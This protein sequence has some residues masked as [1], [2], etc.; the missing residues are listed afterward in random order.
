[1]VTGARRID[2]HA[3]RVKIARTCVKSNSMS[4]EVGQRVSVHRRR[5]EDACSEPRPPGSPRVALALLRRKKWPRGSP[6]TRL[7]PRVPFVRT[8]AAARRPA[9]GART[10]YRPEG[11]QGVQNM[12][13][14]EGRGSIR[15]DPGQI[16]L[17]HLEDIASSLRVHSGRRVLGRRSR[18]IPAIRLGESVGILDGI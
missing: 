9:P 18:N 8:A 16:P 12:R 6:R 3:M 15:V 11:S 7:R 14:H 4:L 5:L 2:P 1:M 13:E 10:S 17:T